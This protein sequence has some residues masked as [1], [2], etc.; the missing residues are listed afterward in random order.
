MIPLCTVTTH[1][2]RIMKLL[3]TGMA[4]CGAFALTQ[5]DAACYTVFIKS[6]AVYRSTV[7]PVDLSLPLSE[8]VPA[9]F[10]PGA[11]M[12]V[13]ADEN[14]CSEVEALPQASV[15]SS[16]G[17]RDDTR[18]STAAQVKLEAPPPIDLSRYFV[19]QSESS[20][21]AGGSYGTGYRRGAGSA[22]VYTGPRGGQ[23]TIPPAGNKS[24][25]SSQGKGQR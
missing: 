10:G 4:L 16:S 2:G 23:N 24:Y 20:G 12:V 1:C 8:T 6:E 3:L 13:S 11:T 5:A 18:R 22:T 7:R 25:P 17:T 19:E 14:G 9:R 21:S 15:N